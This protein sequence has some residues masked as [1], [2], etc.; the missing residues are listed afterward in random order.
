MQEKASRFIRLTSA[1]QGVAPSLEKKMKA[2]TNQK[3]R[4]K[5][6]P[7]IKGR[8]VCKSSLFRAILVL[9][10]LVGLL[11]GRCTTKCLYLVF[12]HTLATS[13][14][15]ITVPSEV[16]P[17]FLHDLLL[18]SRILGG[19]LTVVKDC[20]STLMGNICHFTIYNSPP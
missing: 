2:S 14:C 13:A 18:P 15:D 5:T 9:E 17:Y 20:F 8:I 1:K 11:D 4:L 16:I 7:F 3:E 19:V 6:I 10:R 12:S